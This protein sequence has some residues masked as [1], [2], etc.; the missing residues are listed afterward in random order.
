MRGS[1]VY[2]F[3]FWTCFFCTNHQGTPSSQSKHVVIEHLPQAQHSPAQATMHVC[4][5]QR[6][7]VQ[8]TGQS[9]RESQHVVENLQLAFFFRFFFRWAFFLYVLGNSVGTA[10]ALS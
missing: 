4:A 6:A 10:P 7:T 5:D 9:G 2:A 8:E 1:Y 3:F